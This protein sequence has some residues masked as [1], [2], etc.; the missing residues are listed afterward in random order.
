MSGVPP[1]PPA[2]SFRRSSRSCGIP[3]LAAAE[4]RRCAGKG[5]R[6]LSFPENPVPLGLPSYWTNHWDPMWEACDETDVVLCLHIGTSGETP[7][8]S[9]EAPD[10][11]TF[12]MLQV[13]S[14]M[15]SVNLMMSPVCRKFPRPQVRVLRGRH[16]LAPQ[17]PRAG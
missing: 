14:I 4:I 10:L 15:S 6:A 2:C 8:P 5:A 12:S 11:L 7:Q 13:G 9:P 16:R 17:R 3:G 1:A